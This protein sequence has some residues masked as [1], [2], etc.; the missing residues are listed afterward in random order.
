ML[1]TS[2]LAVCL[3]AP[4]S[5]PP[6][7]V[8]RTPAEADDALAGKR[9][10]DATTLLDH[11][12]QAMGGAAVDAVRTVEIKSS[13]TRTTPMGEIEVATVV[14]LAL[15]GRMRQEVALPFGVVT[16]VL[17]ARG[18][19]VLSGKEVVAL[20]EAEQASLRS[21][22]DRNLIALLQARRGASPAPRFAGFAH[23]GGAYDNLVSV[24]ADLGTTL[25]GI[26]P[27][28]GEVRL[29][30]YNAP[31]LGGKVE[32]TYSDYRPAGGVRY[33]FAAVGTVEGRPL[34]TSRVEGFVANPSLAESLFDAPVPAASPSPGA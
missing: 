32:I 5:P 19:F 12:V 31:A 2:L 28:T 13:S 22:A 27:R 3:A 8:P 4:A 6:P 34:F 16:T 15:P 33:P 18:A 21:T 20:P 30:S 1:L 26:D 25:I 7:F 23:A 17:N 10:V 29:V 9:P 24:G 11:A 14:Q